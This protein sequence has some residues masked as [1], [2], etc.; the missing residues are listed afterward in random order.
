M[1]NGQAGND[2][3]WPWSSSPR[4]GLK[5]RDQNQRDAHNL[6]RLKKMAEG[7]VA[8]DEPI[9]E[10]DHQFRPTFF[11]HTKNLKILCMFRFRLL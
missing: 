1:F 3:W 5:E 11:K 7:G 10:N 8:V 9:F 6:P 2:N 4:Y